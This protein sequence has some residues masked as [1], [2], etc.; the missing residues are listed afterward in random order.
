[1]NTSRD[2]HELA[3][4]QCGQAFQDDAAMS[5]HA[6]QEHQ[7]IQQQSAQATASMQ[8]PAGMERQEDRAGRR[9]QAGQPGGS[10]PVRTSGTDRSTPDAANAAQDAGW[11]RLTSQDGTLDLGRGRLS[12]WYE[13]PGSANGVRHAQLS[14]YTPGAIEARRGDMVSVVPEA[15]AEGYVAK[16]TEYQPVPG[17][18]GVIVLDWPNDELPASLR[19]LGGE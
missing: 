2:N 8:A 15:E 16:I 6:D 12:V 14:S 11:A 19:E 1:M 7:N 10:E 5:R 9:E 18:G 4:R 17:G 13:P 3:C